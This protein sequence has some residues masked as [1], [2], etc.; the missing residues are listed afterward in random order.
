VKTVAR[1]WAADLLHVWFH[2]MRPSQRFSRDAAVDAMLARRFGGTL[3]RMGRTPA[4]T[5]LSDRDTARAA[6]LMFDQLPRNLFRDDARAFGHDRQA[7]AIARGALARGW[8]RGLDKAGRQFLMMPLMHS[9]SRA[10]QR[11]SLSLSAR[12]AAGN[13][14]AVW[15]A[16]LAETHG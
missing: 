1:P 14:A 9:E 13:F 3:R 8:D 2:R 4:G 16:L 15:R 6:V 10:D 7:R 5:F 11:L 12:R